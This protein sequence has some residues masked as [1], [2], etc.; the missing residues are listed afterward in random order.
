MEVK[1]TVE[2]AEYQSDGL[3]YDWKEVRLRDVI[4]EEGDFFIT[5]WV[6]ENQMPFYPTRSLISIFPSHKEGEYCYHI[7]NGMA[8]FSMMEIPEEWIKKLL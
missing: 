2:K 6:S 4:V 5:R 1:Y 8:V 7:R 3:F